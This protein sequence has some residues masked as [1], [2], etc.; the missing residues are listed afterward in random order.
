MHLSAWDLVAVFGAGLIAGIINTIAGGGSVLSFPALLWIGVPPVLASATNTVAM[1]PAQISGAFG[2][3]RDIRGTPW[4]WLALIAPSVVGGVVGAYLLLRTPNH[5]FD[6]MA[7]WLVLTATLLLSIQPRV[8]SFLGRRNT[9]P[10]RPATQVPPPR[11]WLAVVGAQ[12]LVAAYGGFFGAGQSIVILA[13]LGLAG[14]ED[15]HRMNGIKNILS[16]CINGVAALYF[17]GRGILPWDVVGTMATGAIIGGFLGANLAY[18]LGRER[19]R[20]VVVV[21][22]IIATVTLVLRLYL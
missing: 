7:P 15:F 6:L 9:G 8:S 17:V 10:L 22:G 16:A 18:R 12:V 2:F 14:L 20:R 19:V 1:W 21:L 13:V 11:W 5:L 4:W 3:R